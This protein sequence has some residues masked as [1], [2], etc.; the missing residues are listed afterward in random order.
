MLTPPSGC[1]RPRAARGL[2]ENSSGLTAET[3]QGS[4]SAPSK[5]S[6]ES[7]NVRIKD[8]QA[9]AAIVLLVMSGNMQPALAQAGA[10]PSGAAQETG[11]AAGQA[12]QATGTSQNT[13]P[14]I[15]APKLT[16]PLYLRDTAKD[17]TRLYP[18]FPNPLKPYTRTSYDAPQ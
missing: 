12:Q 13:L 9:A 5:K 14:S 1:G 18:M 11:P 3:A 17:Y 15:P 8:M 4:G 16:E 10:A 7:T 2:R 6:W